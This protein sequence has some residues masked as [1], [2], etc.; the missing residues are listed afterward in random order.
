MNF[1]RILIP[2]KSKQLFLKEV[3]QT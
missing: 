2:A 3:A 1:K